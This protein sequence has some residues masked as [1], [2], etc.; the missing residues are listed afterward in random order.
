MSFVRKKTIILGNIKRYFY[1]NRLCFLLLSGVFF[2]G[3]ITGIFVAIKRCDF[4]STEI[5][6]KFLTYKLL[7]CKISCFSFIIQKFLFLILIFA[8]IKLLSKIKLAILSFMGLMFFMSYYL[9]LLVSTIIVLFGFVGV[10][11][12][13]ILLLPFEILI[14]TVLIFYIVYCLRNKNYIYK[15]YKETKEKLIE[16]LFFVAFLLVFIVLQGISINLVSSTIIFVI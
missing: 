14:Y 13:I 16:N 3:L 2:L 15:C 11:N 12:S 8:C 7:S 6:N 5:L 4:L 1:E 9:G 10:L